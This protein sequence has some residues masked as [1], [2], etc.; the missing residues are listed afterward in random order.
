MNSLFGVI[1]LTKQAVAQQQKRQLL[2]DAKL[3]ELIIVADELRAAHPGCGVE[4]MYYTLRPNFLGRDRFIALFMDLGYRLETP[5]NRTKTTFSV[6]SKY[7]NLISGLCVNGINQVVQSD[8]SYF[9]I[10][11][12]FYYLVFIIDIYSKRIV[13]YQVSDHMRVSANYIALQQFKKLRG[14]QALRYCIHHSDRGSQYMC[15]IYI[16]TLIELGCHISVGFKAQENA[17]AERINRT[18]KNE[19]LIPWKVNSFL[20]LKRDVKRAVKHYNEQRI[21]NH[22]PN[23]MT[24]LEFEKSIFNSNLENKHFERI[25]AKENY[26]PRTL[27]NTNNCSFQNKQGYFCPVLT[28]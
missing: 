18:I 3:T 16:N 9:R 7:E 13:G 14:Q 4:K 28:N 17:Y 19:Y 11:D 12:K 20:Q 25:Y 15:H 26:L 24:P 27:W 1:G 8:I 6:F 10:G 23:K 22:L 5:K 21:H 2:F